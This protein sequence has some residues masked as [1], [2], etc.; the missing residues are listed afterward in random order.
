MDLCL[1]SGEDTGWR[2]AQVDPL[3]RV[4]P[5]CYTFRVNGKGKEL[6]L[7]ALTGLEVSRRLRLPDF[8]TIGT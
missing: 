5:Y 7:Q 8:K 2:T 4:G 1:S 6:P 3:E